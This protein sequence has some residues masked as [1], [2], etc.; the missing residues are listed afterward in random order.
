MQCLLETQVLGRAGARH[1]VNDA[2]FT[3]EVIEDPLR[4]NEDNG[5]H[6]G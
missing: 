3:P 1:L 6:I 2:T 5:G 4:I